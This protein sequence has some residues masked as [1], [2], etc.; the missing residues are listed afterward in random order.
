MI[1]QALVH[2][3]DALAASGKLDKPGWLETKVSWSL[4][5]DE[6]GRL[7][8][9]VPVGLPDKKGK[10]TALAMKLPE[11]AA[12]ASHKTGA[13]KQNRKSSGSVMEASDAVKTSGSS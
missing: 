13:E 4:E 9:A 2:A 12:C 6:E 7:V 3:Y 11:M 10:G 1:L 5:L 8:Q